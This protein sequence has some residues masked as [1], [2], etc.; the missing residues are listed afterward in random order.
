MGSIGDLIGRSDAFEAPW[1]SR[2]AQVPAAGALRPRWSR[3]PNR[4][5]PPP[6]SRICIKPASTNAQVLL[7]VLP[8]SS[9]GGAIH[10]LVSFRAALPLALK[11]DCRLRIY[12]QLTT[13]LYTTDLAADLVV[14]PEDAA[15]NAL[16]ARRDAT[17]LDRTGGKIAGRAAADP[18][19]KYAEA[20]VHWASENP[21]SLLRFA[22][23]VDRR[24]WSL[25]G[26]TVEQATELPFIY[27]VAA[28]VG[29]QHELDDFV[30]SLYNTLEARPVAVAWH[31]LV[32]PADLA[33]CSDMLLVDLT[34]TDPGTADGQRLQHMAAAAAAARGLN[35]DGRFDRWW[36]AK[37]PADQAATAG[38]IFALL[39]ARLISTTVA[40]QSLRGLSAD[41][42]AVMAATPDLPSHRAAHGGQVSYPPNGVSSRSRGPTI[43]LVALAA[44][45]VKASGRSSELREPMWRALSSCLCAAPRSTLRWHRARSVEA[46]SPARPPGALRAPRQLLH[47]SGRPE[48]GA[49]LD[50]IAPKL[51]RAG[52]PGSAGVGGPAGWTVCGRSDTVRVGATSRIC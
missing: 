26:P 24:S 35:L 22:E 5:F 19:L 17:L 31:E 23:R 15:A 33:Q 4:R 12:T 38:R 14:L 25:G 51:T 8:R 34:L 7:A 37:S 40:R 50:Q 43:A 9:C 45:M 16:A 48:A 21:E 2:R 18:Y 3:R 20:A 13:D 36:C 30:R 28:K 46:A 47:R 52:S 41:A 29:D 49:L 44:W 11:R 6:C 1:R 32:T 39:D 42:L 27:T 10:A